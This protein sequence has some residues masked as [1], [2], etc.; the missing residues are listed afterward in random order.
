MSFWREAVL[1]FATPFSEKNVK[2][3]VTRY[4]IHKTLFFSCTPEIPQAGFKVR[5]A[6]YLRI[7]VSVLE[8]LFSSPGSVS[9]SYY[10]C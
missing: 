1:L 5:N 6:V 4:S 2:T 8:Y 9:E 3:T 7:L 10:Y